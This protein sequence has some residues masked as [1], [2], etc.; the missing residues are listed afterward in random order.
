MTQSTPDL[1]ALF[2]AALDALRNNR[3]QINDL[4]GYNGNHGDNMVHNVD[5][6]TQALQARA[7]QP[8]AQA[9]ED[10]AQ[11][12]RTQ[13]HGGTSQYYAQGLS[14]AA[15][16]F[17]GQS[18]LSNTDVM[19]LLQSLLGSIPTQGGAQSAPTPPSG[20]M[21]ASLLGGLAGA[22]APTAPAQPAPQ[23]GS[24]LEALLGTV[25]GGAPPAQTAAQPAGG[26]LLGGL[27]GAL[28][29]QSQVGGSQAGGIQDGLGLDDVMN[30]AARFVQAKQSG[31]DNLTA[32]T[33]AAMGA[34]MGSQPLQTSS[35]RAAAGGL[36]AQTVLGA[37]L[38]RK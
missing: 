27:L 28:G 2:G 8:P 23:G 36:I 34:L 18:A 9:L 32:V 5:V 38:G 20:D 13:G 6:I 3:Q 12:L 26:D 24:V 37:L 35:P 19:G 1:G 33:Q 10:A 17:R 29:G 14:Q 30:A 7:G 4:D 16:K 15:E 22:A 21:L 11:R 25:A 31:G